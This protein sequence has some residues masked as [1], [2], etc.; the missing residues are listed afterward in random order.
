MKKAVLLLLLLLINSL[1]VI[2]H[3]SLAEYK[4]GEVIVRFKPGQAVISQNI[5]AKYGAARGERPIGYNVRPPSFSNHYK[6]TFSKEVDVKQVISDLE[7]EP[8]VIS[9]QPN[10]IYHTF[11]TIPNDPSYGSQWGLT[12]IKADYAWDVSRGTNEVLVAVIDTGVDYNHEDLQDKLNTAKAWNFVSNNNNADDDEGHGTEVSGVIAAK[13]NNGVGVAGTDWNAMILPLKAMRPVAGGGATGDTLD[14][15]DAIYWAISKEADVI[16][17]SLGQSDFD[18]DMENACKAAYQ[19]GVVVVAAAGNSGTNEKNYPAASPSKSVLCI[20]ATDSSDKRAEWASVATPGSNY[21]SWVDVS[22]P[23]TTILTTKMGGGYVNASGTSLATPFVAG[24]AS[25]I[26][27]AYPTLTAAQIYARIKDYATSIDS[28]NPTLPAGSLGTGRIDAQLALSTPN[29]TITSPAS[30]E[31]ISGSVNVRGSAYSSNFNRYTLAALSG[32]VVVVNIA[33]SSTMVNAGSLASWDTSG[34]NG[35]YT[36]KLNVVNNDASSAETAVS[37]H[38]D[39]TA[40]EAAIITPSQ[41]TTIEGSVTITGKAKDQYFNYY[42]LEYGSGSS[43]TTFQTIGTYYVSVESSALGTWETA[44]LSGDY[45][46]RLRVVDHVGQTA[47]ATTLVNIK[48]E[49]ANKEVEAQGTLPLAFVLPNPFIRT[50]TN[51]TSFVYTLAG[52]FD[53]TIYLFDLNGNL[54]WQKS[55]P[56]GDNGGKSGLNNPTWNGKSLYGENL[57]NGV[58]LYQI[59]ADKKILA[60]GKIIILN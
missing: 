20:A 49:A 6:I 40:P 23:G 38:I 30:Q 57:P 16:N 44:G 12:K 14:I 17:L 39:N 37:V 43:P 21:G 27:A 31:Y 46:I 29:A 48:K 4:P 41:G 50:S 1:F 47:I 34:L 7:K 26:K 51:E 54:L 22:A 59:V 9:A 58:Y 33:N 60:R 3:L 5:A 42:V 55:Y 19:A 18:V 11:Q 53:A 56:A 36:I 52:N 13:T 15:A 8:N 32:G 45:T 24:L 35:D 10:F 28:L 2:S 25:L